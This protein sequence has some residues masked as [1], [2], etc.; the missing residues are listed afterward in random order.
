MTVFLL[1]VLWTIYVHLDIL[2]DQIKCCLFMIMTS[3]SSLGPFNLKITWNV[4][5]WN[6]DQLPRCVLL[7]ENDKMLSWETAESSDFMFFTLSFL[8]VSLITVQNG[9]RIPYLLYV[10]VFRD[11]WSFSTDWQQILKGQML[12]GICSQTYPL[13]VLY[14]FRV[15]FRVPSKTICIFTVNMMFTYYSSLFSVISQPH[16]VTSLYTVV[17]FLRSM[18]TFDWLLSHSKTTQLVQNGRILSRRKSNSNLIQL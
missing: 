15:D 13:C 3:Y 8:L 4:L 17:S 1:T 2:R 10:E 14:F 16:S 11:C 5:F 7:K 18:A 9:F 6:W 12:S